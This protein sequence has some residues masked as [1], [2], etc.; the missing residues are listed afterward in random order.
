MIRVSS[1]V[2]NMA[3]RFGT[4]LSKISLSKIDQPKG[5]RKYILDIHS[6]MCGGFLLTLIIS[7]ILPIIF[8]FANFNPIVEQFIFVSSLIINL[9]SIG[10][11]VT[12]ESETVQKE[13]ELYEI[14]NPSKQFWYRILNISNGITLMPLILF[15]TQINPLIVPM[16]I[17]S[18]FGIFITL[19][20][21]ILRNPEFNVSSFEA[22]MISCV[23]G[24]IMT[25]LFKLLLVS[26]GFDKLAFDL[27]SITTIASILIFGVIIMIDT[28][29]AV[30]SYQ[31]QKLDS[32]KMSTELLLDVTNIFVSLIKI[33]IKI[34]GKKD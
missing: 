30:K 27:D 10:K 3:E 18:T 11:I 8:K 12:L 9:V 23:G 25:G 19:T 1:S 29:K 6:K 20:L 32:I 16:A 2:M 24:L 14:I 21:Y 31:Q 33:F 13:D 17:I 22:P 26:F 5:L 34:V 7:Q 15:A 28:E 4:N